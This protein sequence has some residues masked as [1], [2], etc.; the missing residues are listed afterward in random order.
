MQRPNFLRHLR[1]GEINRIVTNTWGGTYNIN[2]VKLRNKDKIRTRIPQLSS[3]RL[4]TPNEECR[5]KSHNGFCLNKKI[6]NAKK[7]VERHGKISRFATIRKNGVTG[8]LAAKRIVIRFK[9][10]LPP[11]L[12]A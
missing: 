11:T 3:L 9:L 2:R 5:F 4:R 6:A 1:N 8:T 7:F 12:F 10:L